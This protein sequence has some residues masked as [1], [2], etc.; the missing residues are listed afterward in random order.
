M[1]ICV[2]K[3]LRIFIFFI[4]G[5]SLNAQ[6]PCPIKVD[7]ACWQGNSI[8]LKWHSASK[9]DE[10]VFKIYRTVVSPVKQNKIFLDAVQFS[11]VYQY[12]DEKIL[13]GESYKYDI[14]YE[15]SKC[16]CIASTLKGR[17]IDETGLTLF[18]ESIKNYV[19][20]DLCTLAPEK[21]I[22]KEN[23]FLKIQIEFKKPENIAQANFR[24][25][26]VYGDKMIAT[27]YEVIA[28]DHRYPKIWI[29]Q[30]LFDAKTFKIAIVSGKDI[31]GVSPF[32]TF[33]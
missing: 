14:V 7:T 6:C 21:L 23:T 15:G 17:V 20:S 3:L 27:T 26:I 2:K 19:Q 9:P 29:P 32:I 8:A 11:S 10:G 13:K 5:Y 24:Y 28:N 30:N 1:T 16:H 31:L 22:A 18:I 12:A 25:F 4:F 33:N